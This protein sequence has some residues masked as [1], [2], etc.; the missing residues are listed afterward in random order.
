MDIFSSALFITIGAAV[1]S[2]FLRIEN[3]LTKVETT[4]AFIQEHMSG[5]QPPLENP[6]K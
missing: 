2:M 4:L 3:R 5:C 6:T 1:V